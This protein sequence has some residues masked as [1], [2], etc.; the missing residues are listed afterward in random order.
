M[1]DFIHITC[2]RTSAFI[3]DEYR[4]CV[5]CHCLLLS[6]LL[7][8]IYWQL[9]LGSLMITTS[10]LLTPIYTVSRKNCPLNKM[11]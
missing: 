1:E 6:I 10:G 8:A 5:P 2:H 4:C 9:L 7:D 11:L 3:V